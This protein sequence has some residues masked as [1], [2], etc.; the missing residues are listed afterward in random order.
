MS[1]TVTASPKL[2]FSVL[3]RFGPGLL[4]LMLMLFVPAGTWHYWEAWVYLAVLFV[5]LTIALVYLMKRSP[6]LLERRM[7]AR[8]K[9][10][11]QQRII[12]LSL[13]PF[14]AAFI[15]PGLDH[16]FGWSHV[17]PAIVLFADAIVLIGYCTILL[18]FRENR[19]ASRV[20]EVAAGQQVIATGPYAIVRHPM[21]VGT[22][23]MYLLSPLALG[24][25]WAVLCA[26]PLIWV[27]VARIRNEEEVLLRD[28]DG[29]AAYRQQVR[30]RLVPGVW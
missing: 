2:V 18:V 3:L 8:E 5:P 13:I 29:Y 24:S 23:L 21:Y 9:E 16:R 1:T 14:L 11:A 28:L 10:P 22:L 12:A 25:Y 17:P 30:Y 26:L 27:L 19:Y 15:L 6:D 4:I 20:V 7:H